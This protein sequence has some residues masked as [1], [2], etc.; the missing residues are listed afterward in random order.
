MDGTYP[1]LEIVYGE[2]QRSIDHQ[3]ASLDE[4]RSRAGVLSERPLS[5]RRS[6]EGSRWTTQ[7]LAA[8]VW[9]PSSP[10]LWL[11]SPR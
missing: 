8:G 11:V 6:W 3:A 10:S 7:R 1:A 9:P 2:A 4:V 5:Q